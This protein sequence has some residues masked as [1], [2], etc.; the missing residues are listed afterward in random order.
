MKKRTRCM[1]KITYVYDDGKRQ[2]VDVDDGTSLMQ[3]ALLNGITGIV[4]ECGGS[5]MCATCHVYVDD[6]FA[7]KLP[8]RSE[9]EN[10]MLECTAS[11]RK[12]SSR[13]SCQLTAGPDLEG[14]VLHM[15]E[16]QT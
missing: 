9:I 2:T 14:L 11:E 6:A 10:E 13:L 16:T 7:D 4:G 3:G 1:A 12:E 5:A 8:P 15:P